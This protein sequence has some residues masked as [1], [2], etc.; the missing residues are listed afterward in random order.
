MFLKLSRDDTMKFKKNIH[1]HLPP[2]KREET[3]GRA[4]ARKDFWDYN[5]GQDKIGQ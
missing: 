5:W 3:L 1:Y 4:N 2:Y